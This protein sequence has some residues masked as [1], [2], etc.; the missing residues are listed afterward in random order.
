MAGS[1]RRIRDDDTWE[2][3]V[4]LGRDSEGR[5]RH[6]YATF[7]GSKRAAERALARMIIELEDKPI[8]VPDGRSRQWGVATTINDAIEGWRENGWE[9]LSPSTT[10]RYENLWKKHIERSIGR[11]KIA[12]LSPYD[13]EKYFRNLKGKGLSE[14]SVRQA[15]AMLHRACRLARKWSN[16]QLPNPIN[17]TELPSWNLDDSTPVRAP[18]VEEVAAL[19]TAAVGYD[20]RFAVFLRLVATTGL[21]RGEACA[22]RWSDVDFDVSAVSVDE[23]IVAAHGGAMTKRPKTRASVRRLAVDSVTLEQLRALRVEQAELALACGLPLESAAFVFSSD[24]GGATPP[25]PDTMSHAFATV[26]KRAK[27]QGD[28]HLHSLRHFQAT[29]LDAVVPEA[30]KQAR[31]GWATVRMARHYTDVVPEEDRRA[32]EH[33]A[34]LFDGEGPPQASQRPRGA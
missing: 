10:L 23:S 32:A 2:L 24:P 5:V 12:T 8:P 7:K 31:L 27:V 1:I 14:A 22:V 25:H 33:V 20:F 17:G 19:L 34:R 21:R 13:V 6:K 18:T 11:R 30:Q 15:R 3:R 4:F 26:R 9:D 28:V 16:N 29:V